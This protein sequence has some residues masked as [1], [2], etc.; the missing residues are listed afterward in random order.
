[1]EALIRRQPEKG[2]TK[3]LLAVSQ[4]VFV[5][6]LC[7]G[8]FKANPA[9][10]WL[11]FDLTVAA[12]G[13]ALVLSA[14][15]FFVT[16]ARIRTEASCLAWFF[17][18]MALAL[19]A[20]DWTPYAIEKGS[21][22][23]TL[24]LLAAFLPAVILTRL[25]GVRRF[26]LLVITLGMVLSAGVVLQLAAGGFTGGL[27]ERTTG[28]ATVT[29]SLA[30]DAG[31]ALV[32]LYAL[33]LRG[34][35][36]L[37][38]SVPC[39]PLVV[40]IV[41]SGARAPLLVAP[42]VIALLTICFSRK[43]RSIAIALVLIA[44][45]GLL[46]TRYSSLLPQGSVM[47]IQSFLQGQYDS[48]AD[49]RRN[50][51]LVALEVIAKRPLGNGFGGFAHFYN[52]GGVTDQVYPHNIV[53]DIAVDNGIFVAALFV[54]IL[55]WAVRKSY[56]AARITPDFQP[57]LGMLLF[58]LSNS[59]ISGELNLD[60]MLFALLGIALQADSLI[61]GTQGCGASTERVANELSFADC[62]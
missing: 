8:H 7:A 56:L 29:T 2:V 23:F 27:D 14:V 28:F 61:A 35:K 54:C 32:G 40:A 12:A 38:M 24:T 47:R 18:S 53:L 37:W 43:Q 44:A 11:P 42:A 13:L 5:I 55:A 33:T 45:G 59:L 15:Y 4:V 25:E 16:G 22:F 62:G 19:F 60:R 50:L 6:F 26:V 58:S 57:L 41:A 9:L 10:A 52:F 48:S 39:L 1:M 30:W 3:P 49:E 20:T 21:R 36:W 34:G 31:L 17:A 46:F 51:N